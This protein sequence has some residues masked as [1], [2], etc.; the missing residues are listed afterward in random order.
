AELLKQSIALSH[1]ATAAKYL[2]AMI[3]LKVGKTK[4]AISILRAAA[5]MEVRS[6]EIYEALGI[7]YSIDSDF[8]RASV[9]F[10]TALSLAPWS[11]NAVHGLAYALLEME[12][13]D[14]A[15]DLLIAYLEK[16]PR[17]KNAKQLLAQAYMDRRQFRSA[18]GQLM[19]ILSEVNES[20]NIDVE[21]RLEVSN[22]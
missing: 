3:L 11:A 21:M 22:G 5:H 19:Q 2:L 10:K 20:E 17:D 6:P 14:E 16:R 1:K 7:A 4:E 8:R 15:R 13:P 18:I 12:N 9:A